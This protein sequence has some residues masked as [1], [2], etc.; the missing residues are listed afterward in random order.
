MASVSFYT[1]DFH[2]ANLN[3]SGLGFF[4]STFGNSVEVGEY[5]ET[6]WVTNSNG[7]VQGLQTNNV[8]WTHPAS[9]SVNGAASIALTAIPNYLATLNLRFDHSVAVKTQ[10]AEFRIYDRNNINNSPS[11]VTVKVAEIRHPDTTQTNNG[12]GNATWTTLYG[13][14]SVLS[15]TASPGMSGLRPNGADTTSTRHDYYAVLSASP[16]SIGSKLFA[17]YFSLEYL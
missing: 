13:S 10:N 7:T 15:M 9:G 8:Q 6:T 17:G 1:D 12:S 14:G 11:G 16:D 2:V 5:Q 3:G 4:G